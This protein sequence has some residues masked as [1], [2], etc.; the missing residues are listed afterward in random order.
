MER[1]ETLTTRDYTGAGRS[2]VTGPRLFDRDGL[3]YS[4]KVSG[5]DLGRDQT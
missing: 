3:R 2:A 5:E 4:L 1:R